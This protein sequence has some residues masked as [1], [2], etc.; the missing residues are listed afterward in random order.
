VLSPTVLVAAAPLPIILVD[1][2]PESRREHVY[3]IGMPAI[4]FVI[5]HYARRCASGQRGDANGRECAEG[6]Y[7]KVVIICLLFH[8]L[9]NNVEEA[10]QFRNE[11]R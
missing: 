9:R 6:E 8:P 10:R 2:E 11:R 7:L 4:T 5:A 3:G 1:G